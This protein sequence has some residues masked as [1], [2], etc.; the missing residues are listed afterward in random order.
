MIK[1]R[2]L[3]QFDPIKDDDWEEIVEG[4]I[5]RL[6]LKGQLG[7]LDI[8]LVHL[9]SGSAGKAERVECIQKVDKAIKDKIA[10]SQSSLATSTLWSTQSLLS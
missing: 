8:F 7:A 6:T 1:N 10:F 5:A 2:F 9:T 4:R 3:E